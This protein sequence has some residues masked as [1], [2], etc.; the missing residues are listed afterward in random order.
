MLSIQRHIPLAPF[1]TLALGGEAEY[2]CECHS[3]E[4][5]RDAIRYG[6]ENSLPV[7]VLG[8]GSNVIFPDEG[9]PGLVLMPLMNHVSEERTGEGLLV[10]VGAGIKWD[11]FV[12]LSV[13]RGYGDA[14]TLSGIPGNTGA[15]PVQNVGAYGS[16]VSEIIR[17]VRVFDRKDRIE[18]II[19]A[20]EC[21]F[22]Y[23]ASRFKTVDRDRFVILEATFL[24]TQ[25]ESI[26]PAYVDLIS[27]IGD[28]SVSCD[29]KSLSEFRN[30]VMDIRKEKSMIYDPA[31]PDSISAGSFFTN[32]VVDQGT[33]EFIRKANLKE[34]QSSNGSES[35]HSVPHYKTDNGWK[36]P[37]AWL[38]EHSGFPRGTVFKGAGVS[39]KHTLA[40][41]N[42]GGSTKDLLD[43]ASSIQMSVKKKFNV[44][45]EREPVYALINDSD[46]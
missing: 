26:K 34:T 32:P 18:R 13:D 28:S 29:T 44:W 36:I 4:D 45:L 7:F 15:V 3:D 8:G 40:L 39:S 20:A 25:N 9:W 14:V 12:L 24:L 30:V 2:L 35:E 6:D 21:D 41:I 17:E 19:P 33:L 11:D 16:E 42:R 22:S 10:R 46:H 1:T 31:D 27:R 43:L 5:V 37:A 38:V 23:R